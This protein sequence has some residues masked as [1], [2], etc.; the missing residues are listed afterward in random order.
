[1][2]GE[3]Y[4]IV[5][6]GATATGK[7]KTAIA[8][9]KHFGAEIISA[10]SR[11]FYRK[12]DIG[13]AKP[14]MVEL[15]EVPHHFI[16]SLDISQDY[17]VGDFEKDALQ[18]I[19]RLHQHRDITVMAG[20]SGLYIEAVCFGLDQFP[21][22]PTAVKKEL[23]VLYQNG[24]IIALQQELKHT[25]PQYWEKVDRQNPHRLLRALGICRA[26]GKPYSAFLTNEKVKRNFIPVFIQLEMDRNELYQRIE[27]RVDLMINQG[28]L[29][30]AKSLLSARNYNSLQTVGYVELFAH[31]DGQFS[32]DRAVDL[33]K[34][35]TRRFAKRQMT[36]FRKGKYWKTFHP[37]ETPLILN[38]IDELTRK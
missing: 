34:Q 2:S 9:A 35:N 37:S 12:M 15:G 22:V 1:M 30:E 11:Q 7:T 19:S 8:V 16:N 38:Y 21:E 4:V 18:T 36:W 5:I 23:E 25:D 24:G 17:S 31:L 3:K 33:I 10:D 32:L 27:E 28:L 14:T 13:T 6:G 26:S 20:G 29:E